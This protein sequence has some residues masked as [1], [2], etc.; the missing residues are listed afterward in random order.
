MDHPPQSPPDQRPS[1][2]RTKPNAESFGVVFTIYKEDASVR[3]QTTERA[4]DLEDLSDAGGILFQ[5][6]DDA[7]RLQVMLESA[8]KAGYRSRNVKPRYLERDAEIQRLHEEGLKPKEIHRRIFG[9]PR[10]QKNQ[11]GGPLKY[12][13]VYSVI[14]R[15]KQS[16]G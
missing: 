2:R 8:R 10:W 12:G 9:N 15:L 7:V 6:A 11:K 3:V 14:R 4:G 13:A 5:R 1:S 16:T